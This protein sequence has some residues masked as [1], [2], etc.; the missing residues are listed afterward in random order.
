MKSF[1]QFQEE[2]RQLDEVAPLVAA[3]GGLAMK[4]IGAGLAAYS[5]IDAVKQARKGNYG[6]AGLSALG[7]IP[8]AGIFRGAKFLS[9]SDKIAKGVKGLSTVNKFAGPEGR[10]FAFNALSKTKV[11]KNKTNKPNTNIASNKSNTKDA[12]PDPNRYRDAT[13]SL[14]LSAKKQT[15]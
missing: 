9:K 15:A 12:P 11:A 2:S 5:A 6:R 10:N 13:A 14:K 3:A 1:K 7:A 4:G 8:G